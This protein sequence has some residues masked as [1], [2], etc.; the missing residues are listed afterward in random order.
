[1]AKS[2][3]TQNWLNLVI[4]AISA[5]ILAFT[6]LGRF[7]ES[8]EQPSDSTTEYSAQHYE[9]VGIDFGQLQLEKKQTTW[10]AKPDGVIS[11]QQLQQ[12]IQHWQQLLTLTPDRQEPPADAEILSANTVLL[13]FD[14]QTTPVICKVVMTTES[15]FVEFLGSNQTLLIETSRAKILLPNSNIESELSD[16]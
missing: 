16:A 12:L 13:Y 7:F 6:L 11:A 5:L 8:G 9:L 10:R 15:A 1:M 14:G 3:T 2:K 4:I